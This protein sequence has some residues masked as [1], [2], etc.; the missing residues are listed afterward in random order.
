MTAVIYARY[1]SDL[2]NDRSIEDQLDLC[3]S[4]A[5][6]QGWPIVQTYEDRAMSGTTFQAR[7]GLQRLIRDA[8]AQ[9]LSYR[10]SQWQECG[11]Y[12]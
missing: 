1:S 3:Q 6:A 11:F 7:L 10:V 9:R 2:Q 8:K 5:A 12:L 4:F